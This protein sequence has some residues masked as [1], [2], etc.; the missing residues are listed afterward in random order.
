MAPRLLVL[1][2][3]L[4]VEANV[5]LGRCGPGKYVGQDKTT[6]VQLPAGGAF[7]LFTRLTE[8]AKDNKDKASGGR[9]VGPCCAGHLDIRHAN[10]NGCLYA[11]T[12]H[13]T[14]A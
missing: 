10:A 3:V 14:L 6:D 7:W 9:H 4:Q 11:C 12:V 1:Y 8:F 5:F 13:G 2:G